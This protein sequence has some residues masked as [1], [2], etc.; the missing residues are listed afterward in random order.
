MKPEKLEAGDVCLNATKTAVAYRVLE[1]IER[2]AT[3][4]TCR[5][6]WEPDMGLDVRVLPNGKNI[7]FLV[8]AADVSESLNGSWDEG[9]RT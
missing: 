3:K 4:T 6:Q 2:G 5:I 8:R 7:P 1:V 9:P